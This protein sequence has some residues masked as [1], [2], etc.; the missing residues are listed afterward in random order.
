MERTRVL[1]V[2]AVREFFNDSSP[3]TPPG[4]ACS[5]PPASCS[6]PAA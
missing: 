5:A 3:A 6:G 2:R 1:A 4:S